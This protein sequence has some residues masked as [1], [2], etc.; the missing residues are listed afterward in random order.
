MSYRIST[1]F[2]LR[3]LM[4]TTTSDFSPLNTSKL[5]VVLFLVCKR[6][7]LSIFFPSHCNTSIWLA[8]STWAT[9]SMCTANSIVLF[10]ASVNCWFSFAV[11]RFTVL[12]VTQNVVCFP[13]HKYNILSLRQVF[14]ISNLNFHVLTS[15][16]KFTSLQ[17]TRTPRLSSFQPLSFSH[18]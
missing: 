8:L 18:K 17:F 14:S 5:L 16:M 1:I 9:D 13:F 15:Y 7:Q 4:F 2:F 6:V 11:F 10:L 3:P 12:Y